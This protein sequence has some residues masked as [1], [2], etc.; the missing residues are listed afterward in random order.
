MAVIELGRL[1]LYNFHCV[2][3]I[4]AGDDHW[5]MRG[6]ACLPGFPPFTFQQRYL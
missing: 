1:S 6:N 2:S 4:G 3:I 5:S